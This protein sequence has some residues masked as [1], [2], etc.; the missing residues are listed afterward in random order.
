MRF[1][2]FI[3]KNTLTFLPHSDQMKT[4]LTDSLTSYDKGFVRAGCGFMIK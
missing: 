4:A 3:K 2:V 1:L